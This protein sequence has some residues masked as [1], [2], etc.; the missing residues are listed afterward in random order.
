MGEFLLCSG[1][2]GFVD[3][4]AIGTVSQIKEGDNPVFSNLG[5]NSF[6]IGFCI[7]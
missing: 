5:R 4:R 7:S 2:L 1:R 3:A 6:R